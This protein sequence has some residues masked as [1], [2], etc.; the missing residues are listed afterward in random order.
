[1]QPGWLLADLAEGLTG[2]SLV[3]LAI[4]LDAAERGMFDSL[5]VAAAISWSHVNL[6]IPDDGRLLDWVSP[7]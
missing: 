3:G 4:G 2:D 6:E 5:S 7:G 1:L